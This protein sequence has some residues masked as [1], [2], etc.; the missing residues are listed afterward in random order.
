LDT[1]IL[2]SIVGIVATIVFGIVGVLVSRNRFSQRQKAIG[3]HSTPIQSGR[4]TIIVKGPAIFN[5]KTPDANLDEFR[6]AVVMTILLGV[7]SGLY[8]WDKTNPIELQQT[9][10]LHVAFPAIVILLVIVSVLWLVVIYQ[11]TR[12]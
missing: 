12:Y 4:D 2:L 6:I 11:N 7:V 10:L 9:L 3:A 8:I 5:S 1:G